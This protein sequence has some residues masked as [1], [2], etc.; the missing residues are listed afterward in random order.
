MEQMTAPHKEMVLM[1]DGSH[2][3]HYD[4][5]EEFAEV[6]KKVISGVER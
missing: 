4:E 1:K 5:P 6:V 2:C 3:P